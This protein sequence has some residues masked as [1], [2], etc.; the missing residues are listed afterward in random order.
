M[1]TV[2]ADTTA[3]LGTR[4]QDCD[5]SYF[6]SRDLCPQCY[7]SGLQQTAIAQPGRLATWTVVRVAQRFPV[8]YALCYADFPGDVRVLGRIE[9]WSECAVLRPGMTVHAHA[10]NE[11]DE[12]GRLHTTTHVFT[13]EQS[14][15]EQ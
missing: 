10:T 6:P 3:L 14:E 2:E 13:V 8:P 15:L 5:R 9:N 11:P 7:R 12:S 1:T 4:C